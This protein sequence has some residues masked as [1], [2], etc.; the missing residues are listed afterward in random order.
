MLEEDTMNTQ[1]M[2]GEKDTTV[3]SGMVVMEEIVEEAIM[4]VVAMMEVEKVNEEKEA[5]A[6]AIKNTIGQIKNRGQRR[7]KSL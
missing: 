5:L 2:N 4:M 3:E 1:M 6:L 7:Q